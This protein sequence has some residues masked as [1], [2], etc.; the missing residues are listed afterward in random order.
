MKVT[1]LTEAL[2]ADR[3][4]TTDRSDIVACWSCG[5]TFSRKGRRGDLNGNFCSMRCQGWYDAG[6]RQIEHDHAEKAYKTP[7]NKW[8]V[9]A[10]P[11]GVEVGV[12]YYAG[13]LQRSSTT[14][15]MTEKGYRIRCASCHRKFESKGL[16]CCSSECERGYREHQENLAA[17]AEVGVE[18]TRKRQ[19]AS[20]GARIPTWR[21]GRKVSSSTRFCSPKCQQRARRQS[22]PQKA[23][24][25]AETAKKAA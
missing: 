10:G 24:L 15:I 7:I 9:V 2:L 5:C 25:N 18:P 1:R 13:V 22:N 4:E 19:C 21:K 11:P 12:P 23:V 3:K 17:M 20:C 6:N 14:T 8:R 16:R